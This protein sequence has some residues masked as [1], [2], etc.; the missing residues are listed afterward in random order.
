MH[1]PVNIPAPIPAPTLDGLLIRATRDHDLLIDMAYSRN[2]DRSTA[3]QMAATALQGAID[4]WCGDNDAD[5]DAILPA[6]RDVALARLID[7]GWLARAAKHEQDRA[8]WV[9]DATNAWLDRA[10][11]YHDNLEAV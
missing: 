6:L 7:A 9:A 2:M 4:D 1:A 11:F 5:A 10:D 8:E 3:L